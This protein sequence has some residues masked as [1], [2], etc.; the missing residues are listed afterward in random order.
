[1][2]AAMVTTL[3]TTTKPK[4]AVAASETSALA[5]CSSLLAMAIITWAVA[6]EALSLREATSCPMQGPRT[7]FKT[8]TDSSSN[9]RPLCTR[10]VT[11]PLL[12]VFSNPAST[13]NTP[14]A[15]TVL[16]TLT[17]LVPATAHQTTKV[18]LKAQAALAQ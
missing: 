17:S 10:P 6:L 3:A 11:R 12:Q 14:A 13:L 4:A 15:T 8:L 9:C 2:G 7:T 1:M 16:E 18:V 5:A